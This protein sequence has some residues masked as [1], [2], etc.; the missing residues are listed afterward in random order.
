[1]TKRAFSA[2]ILALLV[3]A[4]VVPSALASPAQKSSGPDPAVQE[5]CYVVVEVT[6]PKAKKDTTKN[7]VPCNKVTWGPT[8]GSGPLAK[9]ECLDQSARIGKIQLQRDRKTGQSSKS[10]FVQQ[11]ARAANSGS[12]P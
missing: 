11:F 3:A 1:M 7:E 12:Q 10:C 8:T 4:L 2:T 5:R 6:N 9:N